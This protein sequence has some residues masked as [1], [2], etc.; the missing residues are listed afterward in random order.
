[1]QQIIYDK[2]PYNYKE[3]RLKLENSILIL[4]TY[5]NFYAW[6]SFVMVFKAIEERFAP[7]PITTTYHII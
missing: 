1:M 5:N 4:H 3:R 2:Q 6:S 7:F